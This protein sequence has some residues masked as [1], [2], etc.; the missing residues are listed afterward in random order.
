MKCRFCGDD[1]Y[2]YAGDAI[3]ISQS[4]QY[5]NGIP[6]TF[7][8]REE[9]PML[10]DIC[11]SCL[12]S[13][14][15]NDFIVDT[16]RELMHTTV[17]SRDFDSTDF[18]ELAASMQE[19][20]PVE[21]FTIAGIQYRVHPATLP[22]VMM[23]VFKKLSKRIAKRKDELKEA[24]RENDLVL[25]LMN[26]DKEVIIS[27][28]KKRGRFTHKELSLLCCT[29]SSR[30]DKFMKEAGCSYEFKELYPILD[31]VVRRIRQI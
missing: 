13:V 2:Y 18:F 7:F 12:S 20:E 1:V 26:L 23:G 6:F 16:M 9:L 25:L 11:N 8:K 10:D 22:I 19:V 28:A 14:L 29:P 27:S 30:S 21:F 4:S 24:I 3:D 5:K 31:N 17:K 15:T